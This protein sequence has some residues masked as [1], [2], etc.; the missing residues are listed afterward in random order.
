MTKNNIIKGTYCLLIRLNDDSRIK[1]GK[2]GQIDFKSGY[3]VYVG[4]ALNSL[5]GRIKRHLRNDKK[6]FWHVDYLLESKNSQ[7]VEVFYIDDGKKHECDVATHL[8]QNGSEVNGFGCSD[9]NCTA[10]LFYFPKKAKAQTKIV[11]AFK[12]LGIKVKKKNNLK[13]VTYME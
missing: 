13:N 4:S 3:Y 6:L 12:R 9:C 7:V 5:E 10:H 1:V 2:K 8:S 11:E